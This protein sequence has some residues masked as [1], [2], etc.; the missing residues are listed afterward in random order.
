MNWLANS[1]LEV[2]DTYYV[3]SY[4][5]WEAW[6]YFVV[7]KWYNKEDNI[8]P[9]YIENEEDFETVL[10]E[11]LLKFITFSA[12]NRQMD[13]KSSARENFKVQLAKSFRDASIANEDNKES[14]GTKKINAYKSKKNK[15]K[16]FLKF[17][18]N[19]SEFDDSGYVGNIK[20]K[21]TDLNRQDSPKL[22]MSE[23]NQNSRE[24][25]YKTN[26]KNPQSSVNDES[27]GEGDE[28]PDNPFDQNSDINEADI[29]Q[30]DALNRNYSA[31]VGDKP[32]T[33][34]NTDIEGENRGQ[35]K[36]NIQLNR[37]FIFIPKSAWDLFIEWYSGGPE[38]PRKVIVGKDSKPTIELHP[39]LISYMLCGNDGKPINDSVG[40]I[41]VSCTNKLSEVFL[42]ISESY[43][44]ISTDSSRLWLKSEE[45]QTTWVLFNE[46]D[47]NKKI[48]DIDISPNDIF[49]L[50]MK[51]N[52]E[53][54]RDQ[55]DVEEDEAKDWRN[56]EVGDKVDVKKDKEWRI[57]Q[58]KKYLK[59]VF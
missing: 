51:I 28:D 20:K 13:R 26:N 2:G 37:D 40:T 41:F 33:I 54:P 21:I 12:Q 19:S 44:F 53:W 55:Q 56:F 49:M 8:R 17:N 58:V 45:E 16:N 39:P 4:R 29:P 23:K 52:N 43:N 18:K 57:G 35:L 6:R 5:W 38:I 24:D 32:N 9:S 34:D 25:K 7:V 15:N 36:Q 1:H 30:I 46:D 47:M 3:L 50:E 14:S 10:S 22:N 59:K 27:E 31:I 42:K 11:Y 48:E